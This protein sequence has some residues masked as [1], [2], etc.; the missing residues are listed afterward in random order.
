[1]CIELSL[2]IVFQV[3]YLVI[4]N[5]PIY[6]ILIELSLSF[7][8][9]KNVSIVVVK[10]LLKTFLINLL[11]V[12]RVYKLIILIFI[13]STELRFIVLLDKMLIIYYDLRYLYELVFIVNLTFSKCR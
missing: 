4:Y 6:L 7:C 2:L 12:T 13:Q 10:F 9:I 8:F 3:N 11:F 5:S 1:M